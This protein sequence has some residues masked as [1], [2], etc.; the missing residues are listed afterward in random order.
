MKTILFYLSICVFCLSFSKTYAQE[1]NNGISS[2]TN[3]GN[4]PKKGFKY[5]NNFDLALGI[6]AGGFSS[7]LSW[8]KFHGIGKKQR[9][10]IGYS[11]RL[12]NY[13]GSDK[14]YKTALQVLSRIKK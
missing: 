6:G 4:M 3:S 11:L 13:F 5:N 10:K 2:S 7:S 14:V 1:T 8:V 12:S 9:F